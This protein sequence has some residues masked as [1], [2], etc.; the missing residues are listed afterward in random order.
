MSNIFYNYIFDEYEFIIISTV[1]G[2]FGVDIQI[3]FF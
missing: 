2:L 1:G 3:I